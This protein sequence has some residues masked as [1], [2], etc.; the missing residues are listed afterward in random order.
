MITMEN[1]PVSKST[2]SFG[3]SLALCSMVNA[4]LVIAKETS[5]AV[6]TALQRLTGSHWTTHAALVLLLFVAF[7]W[8]FARANHG[9]GVTLPVHRLTKTIVA[10][11]VIAGV[12][13]VGFYLIAD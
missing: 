1:H 11:V 8:L 6:Q 12:L 7:G 2:V 4:L 9:Q 5:P 3:L 10:G 13:I